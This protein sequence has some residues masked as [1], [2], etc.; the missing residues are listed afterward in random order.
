MMS[1][2][3]RAVIS[4]LRRYLIEKKTEKTVRA[5]GKPLTLETRVSSEKVVNVQSNIDASTIAMEISR[6][7]KTTFVVVLADDKENGED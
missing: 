7:V 3:V 5:S 1:S 2:Y 6:H 4:T